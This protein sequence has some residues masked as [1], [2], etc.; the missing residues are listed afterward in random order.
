[1]LISD[2]SHQSALYMAMRHAAYGMSDMLGRPIKVDHVRIEKTTIDQLVMYAHN[3][4]SETVGIY[5]LIGDDLPGQAVLTLSLDDAMYLTDW[6]LEARPGTTTKLGE[7]E[8]SALAELGNLTLSSFLNA[9]A[10]F[11][12]SPLRPSPPGVI[13]D[14]LA[15]IL[16]LIAT[17]VGTVSDELLS[18]Q[19]DFVNIQS[20][21][22][23]QFWVLPNP[24]F[25][26]GQSSLH[27]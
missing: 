2:T 14:M 12:G 9:V 15:T 24:A 18:I 4:E 3:L 6:L 19:A 22:L 16:E 13:V 7:L 20:S 26:Q 27:R 1:M 23:I 10:Q 21:V 5:L 8:R 11:S 25:L 17:S